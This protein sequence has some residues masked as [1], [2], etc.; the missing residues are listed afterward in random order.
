MPDDTEAAA[1]RQ[2]CS[3]WMTAAGPSPI[4]AMIS[5]RARRNA[6]WIVSG[7]SVTL[8]GDYVA[9]LALP[10]FVVQ[11]TGSALDL[12]L[13]TAL[14]TLPTLLFGFAVGVMLDRISIRWAL[15][16]ADVVRAGA[17]GV[18]AVVAGAGA[19]RVWMVFVVAFLVG[20]MTVGF[21]S[22][23]QTWLP[24]LATD[25]SLVGI[26]SR[27]QFVRTAAWTVGPPLAG[28]LAGAAGGF[29]IAFGLNAATFVVSA[30]IVLALAEIRPR[31]AVQ[32]DPWL[33]SFREGIA[34]L[35]HEPRL[36]SATLAGT[37]ANLAFVPM[38]ALLVLFCR[39]RLG[40]TEDAFIGWFFG[41]HALL[42]AL[43]VMA[44]PA[45]TRR[46]GL[47][48]AFVLGLGALGAG[49]LVLD[50]AAPAI[51]ALP[52]WGST[53]AAVFPAGLAVAGVSFVNVAFTTMRQQLPPP[54]L[55]GRVIA[56]SR[57]LSWAGLPL[58]ATL[59]GA[60]GQRFGVGPVY[61][62][63]AGAIVITTLLLGLTRLWREADAPVT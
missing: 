59:G 20:T 11:L 60:A 1:G 13:T 63:A 51:E 8:L 40:I 43:G 61:A 26:N 58:G 38:E 21:D 42:G 25:E 47:G 10:L 6:W 50:L 18:L 23:F 12:G 17:F 57:T 27:L 22:G 39:R 55:R 46:I 3:P 52:I 32:R 31:P 62:G 33:A 56:A 5:A 54:R 48:R 9:L 29:A 41:G 30:V 49:F 19:G 28:V 37:A 16:I 4:S 36:R 53:L 24:A 45:V 34:Y 14:E 7:Q 2:V 15:V 44:A 35:W